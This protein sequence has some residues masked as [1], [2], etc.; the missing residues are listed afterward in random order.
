MNQESVEK[1]IIDAHETMKSNEFTHFS[2]SDKQE[3]ASQALL[4][5]QMARTQNVQL[6]SMVLEAISFIETYTL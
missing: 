4:L 1:A 6:S 3:I 2:M 5:V